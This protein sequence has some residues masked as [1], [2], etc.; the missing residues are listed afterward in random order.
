MSGKME[1]NDKKLLNLNLIAK[2]EMAAAKKPD[3]K[4]KNRNDFS[5]DNGVRLAKKGKANLL[6][7]GQGT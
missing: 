7:T 2:K 3:N 4:F 1:I 5:G 6:Q